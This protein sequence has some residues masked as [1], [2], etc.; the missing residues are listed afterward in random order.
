MKGNWIINNYATY[1]TTDT[2]SGI[3][4]GLYYTCTSSTFNCNVTIEDENYFEYNT[5]ENSGGGMQWD[6][7]EP[8]FDTTNVFDNNIATLY[9]DNIACFAEKIILISSDEYSTQISRRLNS[10]SE[11]ILDSTPLV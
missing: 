5:A 3:G 11:R 10:M 2:S 9:A 4:G 1:L 8:N 7:V 6:N